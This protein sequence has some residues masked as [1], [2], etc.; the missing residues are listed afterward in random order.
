MKEILFATT[1]ENK[2]KEA[3][4][5]LGI[6][7][8][9]A[10]IEVVEIQDEDS[11]KIAYEKAKSAYEQLKNPVIVDDVSLGI[12]A[13]NGFPGPLVKFLFNAIGNDGLLRLLKDETNRGVSVIST[14]AYHDGKHVYTFAGVLRGKLAT[15]QRGKDGWG[16]DP[17]IIAEGETKTLAELGRERKNEIS[18]R[19]RAFDLLKNHLDSQK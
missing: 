5:I 19:K 13:L 11:T 1:N 18:H 8:K 3:E 17:I 2:A 6:P 9:F 16:F 12:N 4:E 14:I 7:V 10:N 15:E